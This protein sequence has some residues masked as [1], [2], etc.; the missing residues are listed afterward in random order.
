MYALETNNTCVNECPNGTYADSST[1]RCVDWCPETTLQ[2]ADNST[3]E[4]VDLCPQT[5]DYFGL[6]RIDGNR[7]CVFTC[8]VG[9]FADPLTRTCV[10]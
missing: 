2:Y 10:Q 3:N 5:P 6:D 9:L 8:D 7:V 4:C 1:R